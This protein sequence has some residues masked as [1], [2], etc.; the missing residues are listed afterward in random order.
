M[1]KTVPS[2]SPPRSL[3]IGARCGLCRS[4]LKE[5]VEHFACIMSGRLF[6]F[7]DEECYN[8]FHVR[9]EDFVNSF[10]VSVNHEEDGECSS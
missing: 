6:I 5:D 8:E 9:F 4:R 10:M 7:C 1:E 2:E 3:I